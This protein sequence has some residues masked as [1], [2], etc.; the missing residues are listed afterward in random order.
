MVQGQGVTWKDMILYK[1][2]TYTHQFRQEKYFIFST[3]HC[4]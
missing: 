1:T 3:E 2:S 4:M